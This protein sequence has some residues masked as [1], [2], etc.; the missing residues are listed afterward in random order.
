M[1]VIIYHIQ[2]LKTCGDC[3]SGIFVFSPS[4][5]LVWSVGWVGVGLFL[6]DEGGGMA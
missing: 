2:C 4:Y 1:F 3:L 5:V 6:S